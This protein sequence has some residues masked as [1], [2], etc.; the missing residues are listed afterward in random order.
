MKMPVRLLSLVLVFALAFPGAAFALSEMPASNPFADYSI[1]N[2]YMLKSMIDVEIASRETKEKSVTIPM[3]QYKVG[4]DIP[5]GNYTIIGSALQYGYSRFRLY[6]PNGELI[7]SE[8][9][10]KDEIIGK[11]VLDYGCTVLINLDQVTFTTYK[12]F[13]F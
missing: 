3:G 2:L 1:E 7:I 10:A 6:S 13:G 9:V 11:V 4:L 8:L 12:G 5:S